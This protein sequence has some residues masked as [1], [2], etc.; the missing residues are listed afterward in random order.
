VGTIEN[1]KN[2]KPIPKK[3]ND[4]F[5]KIITFLLSDPDNRIKFFID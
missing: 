2:N 1:K 3:R 5:L 4:N